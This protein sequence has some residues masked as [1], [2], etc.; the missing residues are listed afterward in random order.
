MI[1][2]GKGCF[3]ITSAC[4]D[5]IDDVASEF[6]IELRR[7]SFHG[8]FRVDYSWQWL[9]VNVDEVAPIQ[10]SVGTF[11]Q[12]NCD[13]ITN[14]AHLTNGQRITYRSVYVYARRCEWRYYW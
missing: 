12:H 4:G 9:V 8:L 13:G 14:V 5:L 7:S 10:R 2:L 1:G 11:G 6:F 3:D